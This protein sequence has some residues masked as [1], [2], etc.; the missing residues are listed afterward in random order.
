LIC[1]PQCWP[2]E[3]T[4]P[5]AKKEREKKKGKR[6]VTP[7]LGFS[8]GT[9]SCQGSPKERRKEKKGR[10]K[11]KKRGKKFQPSFTIRPGRRACRLRERKG[12]KKGERKEG[13]EKKKKRGRR[14]K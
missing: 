9:L 7:T 6:F 3:Q 5:A 10:G 14:K 1:P 13:K 2:D 12:G 11:K 8:K 4:A